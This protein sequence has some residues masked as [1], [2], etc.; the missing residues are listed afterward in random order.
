MSL[1]LPK[2]LRDRP[3]DGA[4]WACNLCGLCAPTEGGYGGDADGF[5]AM[6]LQGER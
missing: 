2:L 1:K 6:A 4:A 3:A 5:A